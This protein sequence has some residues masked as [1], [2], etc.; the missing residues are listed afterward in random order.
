MRKNVICCLLLNYLKLK[1]E[2]GKKRDSQR[3]IERERVRGIKRVR[4]KDREGERD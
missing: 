4:E 1:Q 3:E 2:V